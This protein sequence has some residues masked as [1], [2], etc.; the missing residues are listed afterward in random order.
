MSNYEIVFNLFRK[1]GDIRYFLLAN[2]IKESDT[3]ENSGCEGTSS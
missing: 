2:S 3:N 1:T